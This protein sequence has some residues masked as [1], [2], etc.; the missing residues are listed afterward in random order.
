VRTRVRGGRRLA[1]AIIGLVV[2][3]PLLL[4]V[5]LFTQA[6]RVTQWAVERIPVETEKQL[7]AQAFA[8]FRATAA[9][10]DKHPAL[11]MLRELGT[12]LT[13]GSAYQ[14]EIHVVRDST[15]NAFAMP[16]GYIV[17]HTALLEKAERAEEVAGVLAHEIQHVELRHGLRG[18]VH[19][20]GLRIGLTLLLGDTGGT[21]V[22]ALVENLGNLRFSRS[23][24]TA[25]DLRGVQALVAA[26]IDPRG[27]AEFFK[28]LAKEGGSVPKLLSSRPASEDRFE[29]VEKSIPAGRQ[30]PALPYDIK[31]LARA[32]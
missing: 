19:A 2:G 8:Q 6:D 15:V 1:G 12:R 26:D 11:P 25:A 24:E 14:Y 13:K 22:G 3:V 23:Q 4:L 20:A 30:F 27:M 10:A 18:L 16:G 9:L 29:A 31:A 21:V 32:P 7:G 5:L 28:K 17:F